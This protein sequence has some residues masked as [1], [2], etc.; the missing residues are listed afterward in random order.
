VNGAIIEGL[1]TGLAGTID[2]KDMSIIAKAF[3][4]GPFEQ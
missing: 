2:L 4:S 3:R 1:N